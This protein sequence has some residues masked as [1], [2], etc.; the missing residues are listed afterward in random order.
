MQSFYK[1]MVQVFRNVD[2]RELVKVNYRKFLLDT[3]KKT[4]AFPVIP[5]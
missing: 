4:R 3:N 5:L 2:Q 1:I